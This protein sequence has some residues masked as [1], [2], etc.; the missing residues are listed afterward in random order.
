MPLGTRLRWLIVPALTLLSGACIWIFRGVEIAEVRRAGPPVVIWSPVKAHLADGST[1]IYPAGLTVARDTLHG[2]GS[3]YGLT[4]QFLGSARLVPL[5]SVVGMETYRTVVHGPESFMVSLIAT[6]IGLYASA[7]LAVAIFGS[8]PTIYADTGVDASLEAESFSYSIA[9]LFEVRDL[10]RL[11]VTGDSAGVVRLDVRNEAMET[12]YL[13]HLELLEVRHLRSELALPDERGVPVVVRALGV[14]STAR[15]RRGRDVRPAL[16]ESGGESF[17]TDVRTLAR[18]HAGDT[19]DFI[20]LVF[21]APRGTDSVALVLRLRNSLLNTVL[22]YDFM[23]GGRGARSLDW[24]GQDLERVGPALALAQWYTARMGLRVSVLDGATYR[25]VA[26]VRDTGPIAWKELAVILPATRGDSV[27]VRLAFVADNWR[28]DRVALAAGMA[29][30]QAPAHAVHVVGSDG[31]RDSAATFSLQAADERYLQTNP[32][33]RFSAVFQTAPPPADSART[34]LLASQG[35]YI[36]WIRG[37]W[38]ARNVDS[39]PP[40]D[41]DDA[42]LAALARWRASRAGFE[43]QFTD[44]RVPVR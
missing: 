4:M 7:A 39:T 43:R 41:S 25:Q 37:A 14:P 18:A 26:H 21:P 36:E 16:H 12:H 31:V 17:A 22:L 13:N 28:I 32:G 11:A 27:R 35:Y 6:P 10:D 8:C 34:F 33:Q 19:D 42:L 20:D 29:R 44:S 23:L 9:P 3:R 2:A 24:V 15:D 40:L 30:P 1:V 38:V 5:D